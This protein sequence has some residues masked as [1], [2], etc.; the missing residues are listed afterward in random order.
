MSSADW[1]LL[2][3]TILM[4]LQTERKQKF[5]GVDVL[6]NFRLKRMLF[7]QHNNNG[8]LLAFIRDAFI[9]MSSMLCSGAEASAVIK[10]KLRTHS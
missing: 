9:C 1:K 8:G 7:H 6:K 3:N 2:Q 10:S 4:P 5:G